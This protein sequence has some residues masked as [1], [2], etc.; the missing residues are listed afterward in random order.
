MLMYCAS[1]MQKQKS[2]VFESHSDFI[3]QLQGHSLRGTLTNRNMPLYLLS[4]TMMQLLSQERNLE[5]TLEFYHLSQSL[6][7]VN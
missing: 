7:P 4:D 2:V 6:Q 3:F 5:V 1:L